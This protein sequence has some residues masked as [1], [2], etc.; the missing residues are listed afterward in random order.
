MYIPGVHVLCD[1]RMLCLNLTAVSFLSSWGAQILDSLGQP[2]N[3][4]AT[5]AMTAS[6]CFCLLLVPLPLLV[7]LSAELGFTF[8]LPKPSIKCLH[9]S[10]RFSRDQCFFKISAR[11]AG[12]QSAMMLSWAGSMALT[13]RDSVCFEPVKMYDADLVGMFVSTCCSDP[14]EPPRSQRQMTDIKNRIFYRIYI[15]I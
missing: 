10:L 14:A 6:F 4:A 9:S 2:W 12:L 5:S 15:H 3:G 11:S 8:D 7:L 1:S 13:G